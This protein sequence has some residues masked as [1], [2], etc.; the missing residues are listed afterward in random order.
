MII[1]NWSSFIYFQLLQH[2]A[3]FGE[4]MSLEKNVINISA[5]YHYRVI[6]VYTRNS[7]KIYKKFMVKRN[8]CRIF[9]GF[10]G[11]WDFKYISL[12][13]L[14]LPIDLF[15]SHF[16]EVFLTSF[17]RRRSRKK[18]VYK[19]KSLVRIK[20][21]LWES[22]KNQPKIGEK[23]TLLFRIMRKHISWMICVGKF[24]SLSSIIYSL[25]Y[26]SRAR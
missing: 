18:C 14:T 24:L 6:F 22:V 7:P 1:V 2:D 15:V 8:F 26:N 4:K 23:V 10:W 20:I 25:F 17:L 19:N 3:S 5:R 9:D 12:V 21:F 16:V 13:I 11:G